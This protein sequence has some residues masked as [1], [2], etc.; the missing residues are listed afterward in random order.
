MADVAA[1]GLSADSSQIR[2]ATVALR[3][4]APAATAAERAAERWGMTTDAAGRSTEEFSRRV[5]GTIK[6]LEFER[7]QLTR[8]AAEQAKYAALRRAGVSEASAEGRAIAASVAA[9]QAQRTAAKDAGEA[10]TLGAKAAKVATAAGTEFVGHLKML[11]AAYVG[12]EAVR[13]IWEAGLKAGDLGEQADQIGVT[14][15]EL[16]AFRFAGAQAGIETE[17]MDTAITKLAKSMGTAA[18]GNKEMIELFERLGVKLLDAKGELRPVA[19]VMPEVAR[20]IL[21]IGSTSQ[22]TATLMDLFGRSGAKMTTVLEEFAKGSDS[23]VS[24]ARDL[25]GILDK[26]ISD[27]WDRVGDA[28]TRAGLAADV[29]N[30]KLGAPIATFGLEKVEQI[31]K[32]INGLMEQINSRQ[33]FWASV[34]EESK[35]IGR[36]GSGPNALRL[37]TPEEQSARRQAE[38]Q[39][40]LKDPRNAGREGMIQADIDRLKGQQIVASQFYS[41][42]AA[43][44]ALRGARA[45]TVNRSTGVGSPKVKGAGDAEAKAYQKVIDSAKDYIATKNAETAA[46]GLSVEAASRLKHETEMVSKATNDNTVLT[47]AQVAQLKALAQTMAE[48]DAKL[49]GAKFM[50]E[51]GTK[52][53]DFIAQQQIERDTL[54]MSAEAADA[55]RI[56]QTYLNEAK[57]KGIELSAADVARL[58]DL[59]AQQAAAAEK[60]RQAKEI[61]DLAKDT[62]KGF[63]SDMRQ[64]LMEGKSFW[65]AF[66][67]AAL[68]ALDKIA[69]K[70]LDMA[71]QKLFESA[72]G[73][74]PGSSG[75][76][77]GLF[78]G[79]GGWISNLLGGGGGGAAGGAISG[80]MLS[81]TGGIYAKGAAFRGGNVIPFARGGVVGGPTFFPMANGMG[82][83]GEAGPEAVMPLRRGPGGRLG[84]SVHGGG[85]GSQRPQQVEIHLMSDMLDARIASGAN[86]QIVKASPG[87]QGKAVNQAMKLAPRAVERDKAMRSQDWRTKVA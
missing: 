6:S 63:V 8:T 3:E 60:T 35:R 50:D 17:Q 24:S 68:N 49:A 21:N 12:V 39:A 78:S 48:A 5:Q 61:Y 30:A 10:T 80:G 59:A 86:V 23:V 40:E 25:G 62:F 47:A 4:I 20:G 70:L 77:G 45:P 31:L 38:L 16:Q 65:D 72:F 83:M 37:E 84:V 53:A 76:G 56:A 14:T 44:A 87:I 57:A 29:T 42:D 41:E 2:A 22:R 71:A 79:V 26:D 55:Y 11:A 52:A 19:D 82:L 28:M 33:G 51:A 75:A 54:W 85:Q 36:I 27:A 81:G 9:L 34:L 66:G 58:R 43:G 64:G 32:S 67:N 15:D 46:I 74:A 73:G 13:K 7:Q 18:D 69:S 1:L